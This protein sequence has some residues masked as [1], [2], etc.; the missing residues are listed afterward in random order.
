MSEI[1]EICPKGK[2]FT[3]EGTIEDP[4]Y[5]LGD[6]LGAVS[7]ICSEYCAIENHPRTGKTEAE[8][9]QIM[10]GG[11]LATEHEFHC[12]DLYD[13]YLDMVYGDVGTVPTDAEVRELFAK[14]DEAWGVEPK[15]GELF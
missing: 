7:E 13:E 2:F 8:L 9:R 4:N 12:V 5:S 1:F 10:I 11:G 15:T 14:M 3:Q 6:R